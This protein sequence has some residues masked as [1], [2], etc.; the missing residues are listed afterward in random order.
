MQLT[1]GQKVSYPNQGVCLV[2]EIKTYI[3]G[4]NTV[5]GYGLRILSDNS[6]IFV[7]EANAKSVGLRPLITSRQCRK[8]IDTLAEDFEPVSGDW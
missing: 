6:T 3:V 8:L 7:P 2:E 1:I 4:P 5:S